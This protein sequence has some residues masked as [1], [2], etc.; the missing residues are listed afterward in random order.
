MFCW[1]S[2]RKRVFLQLFSATYLSIRKNCIRLALTIVPAQSHAR[3]DSSLLAKIFRYK[4]ILNM[5]GSVSYP[6]WISYEE[7]S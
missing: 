4:L 5:L 1:A 2:S 3:G 6:I 7:S